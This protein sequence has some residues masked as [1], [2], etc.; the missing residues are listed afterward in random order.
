SW[1]SDLTGGILLARDFLESTGAGT[2][3]LFLLSDLD[4]DL[5][6]ELDRDVP[7]ELAG[8]EVV[9]VNV[10]RRDGDNIDPSHYRRRIAHWRQ[11]VQDNGG[12]WTMADRIERLESVV[13]AR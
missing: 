3:Q 12:Q 1:H 7:L 8:I 4:E 10:I 5:K 2:R 11:R 9:A 6:P 13:A